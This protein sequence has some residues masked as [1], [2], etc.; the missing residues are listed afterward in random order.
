MS[1]NST[2]EREGRL[3]RVR[4]N[5]P[6]KRNALSTALCQELVDTVEAAFTEPSV[7]TILIES[8]GQVFCAGMDLDEVLEPEAEQRTAIHQ[9]LFT[10]GLRARKPIVA[11]VQGPALGGGLGLA[12]NAHIVIAAHGATFGLTEIRIGMWPYVIFPAMAAAVGERRAVELALTGRVFGV[13]EAAQYGIVHQSVPPF[14][15]E[16]RAVSVAHSLAASSAGAIAS[17]LGYVARRREL[18]F[19]DALALGASLRGEAFRGADFREGVAA[20]HE[21]RKPEWPSCAS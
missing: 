19:D 3:L 15:L 9:R 20:F 8:T 12:A 2:V 17:G 14:E 21:K 16:D 13:N 1:T 11:A 6:D 7:G 18:A 5:R 10:L 4:L